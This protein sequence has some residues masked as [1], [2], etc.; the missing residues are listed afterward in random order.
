[1]ESRWAEVERRGREDTVEHLDARL[2]WDR[3]V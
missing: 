1:M 2:D 3:I